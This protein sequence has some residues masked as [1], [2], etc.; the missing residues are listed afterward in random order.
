MFHISVPMLGVIR[1]LHQESRFD[2]YRTCDAYFLGVTIH[3]NM[4]QAGYDNVFD[5]KLQQNRGLSTLVQESLQVSFFSGRKR[6]F[7]LEY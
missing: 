2:V 1:S 5:S 6:N 7:Q 3:S 4:E